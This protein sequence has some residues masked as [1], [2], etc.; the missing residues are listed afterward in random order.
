MFDEAC[1]VTVV[2]FC[3]PAGAR[4]GCVHPAQRPSQKSRIS[5]IPRGRWRL[6]AMIEE[7]ALK[8]IAVVV[9]LLSKVSDLRDPSHGSGQ[10]T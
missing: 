4:V 5:M 1:V 9:V 6:I 10:Y 3:V 2:S 8:D 7:L